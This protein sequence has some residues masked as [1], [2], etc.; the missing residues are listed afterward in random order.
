LPARS[1]RSDR[2]LSPGAFSGRLLFPGLPS[3]GRSLFPGLP[4]SGLPSS[5]LPF[6]GLPFSG[7]WS[8]SGRLL[9]W[10]RLL[11]SGRARASRRWFA[12][13]AVL[14]LALAA[15]A[16]SGK[17]DDDTP[18]PFA[19]CAA[20]VAPAAAGPTQLPDLQ[21]PCFTGGQKVAL[22]AIKAPAVINFWASWCGPC[23]TELPVI[24]ALATKTAGKL[25][26]LGVDTGDRREAGASF[27]AAKQVTMPNLFDSEQTLFAALAGQGLPMTVF[28]DAT[29]RRTIYRL[30]LTGKTL[31]EQVRQHTGVTVPP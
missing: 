1:R 14:V 12:G 4:S 9:F 2:S 23:R 24:Q 19:D 20:L 29:G 30:P 11:L 26:V 7:R 25:T 3:S 13:G 28:V 5:G 6:S 21:L 22:T 10:G 8:S 16:C 27:A 17:G 18:S 15:A 31:P